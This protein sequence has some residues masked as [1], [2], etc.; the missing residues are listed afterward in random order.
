MLNRGDVTVYGSHG[1]CQ[2]REILVPPFL[3]GQ[4]DKLYYMMSPATDRNAVLYVPVEGADEKMRNAISKKGAQELLA[5][6]EDIEEIEVESGKK[7]DAMI[8]DVIKHTETEEMMRL[9]KGLHK[10]RAI[11]ARDGKKLA[12]MNERHLV[13]AEKLLYSEMAFS[14]KTDVAKVKE[15]VMETLETLPI[16]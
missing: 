1:L 6:L 2:V 9:V 3:D 16:A 13:T 5:E 12:S 15:R 8:T 10:A 11:R 4:S 7:A 14:L